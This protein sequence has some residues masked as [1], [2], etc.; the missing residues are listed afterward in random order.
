MPA[1]TIA[2]SLTVHRVSS[3]PLPTFTGSGA[4]GQ[5]AWSAPFGSFSPAQTNNGV[6]STLTPTNESRNLVVTAR[7][8]ADNLTRTTLIEI[9]ATFPYQPDWRSAPGLMDDQTNVSLAEDFSPSFLVKSD[10]QRVFRYG[11]ND[12]DVPTEWAAVKA[13]YMWHRKTRW[14]WIVDYPRDVTGSPELIKVRF[15]SGLGDDPQ[16]LNKQSYSFV[17]REAIDA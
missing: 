1:P 6:A 17:F 9:Q 14:F 2:Q 4:T 3:L 12:R 16:G 10:L 8:S 11:F 15:D 13:F 5:V 7:D